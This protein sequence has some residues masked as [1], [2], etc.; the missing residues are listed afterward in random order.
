MLMARFSGMVPG[1]PP[2]PRQWP[3]HL[4]EGSVGGMALGTGDRSKSSAGDRRWAATEDLPARFSGPLPHERH[5]ARGA[6][7]G[8]KANRSP[9][10]PPLPA[11][12]PQSLNLL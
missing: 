2:L 3:R 5:C 6:P 12:R 1:A 10:G 4:G 9:V 11:P 7:L 8:R